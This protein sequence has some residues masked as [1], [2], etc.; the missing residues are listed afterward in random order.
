VVTVF[1]TPQDAAT[2]GVAFEDLILLHDVNGDGSLD[3]SSLSLETVDANPPGSPDTTF[4]LI[5]PNELATLSLTTSIFS[6]FAIG[7]VKALALGAVAGFL[8]GGGGTN[9]NIPQFGDTAVTS[10][11]DPSSTAA[12]LG[13]PPKFDLN[14]LTQT[15][16]LNTGEFLMFEIDLLENDGINNVEHVTLFI[17]NVG[18]DTNQ[19][20]YDTSIVFERFGLS[21]VVINDPNELFSSADFKI[22]ERDS[23]NFRLQFFITFE[24]PMDTSNIYLQAWDLDKNPVYKEIPNAIMVVESASEEKVAEPLPEWLKLNVE[25][26]SQEQISDDEFIQGI[27]YLISKNI[28]SVS[29]IT[30]EE[31]SSKGIPDWIRNNAEWWSQEIIS[32]DDFL[33][34]IEYLV[35]IGIIQI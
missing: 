32:D 28:I 17:N 12:I 9:P 14:S 23:Q 34:G 1:V 20:D 26:W 18:V 19:Y 33:N 5:I 27:Q 29:V 21:E 30:T 10:F 3:F 7:G 35:N 4:T 8:G 13:A 31:D 22:I 16:V 15:L 25:W 24:K 11:G 2:A 6:K